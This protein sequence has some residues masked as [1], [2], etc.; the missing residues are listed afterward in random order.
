MYVQ[1]IMIPLSFFFALCMYLQYHTYIIMVYCSTASCVP[2]R[3]RV[4]NVLFWRSIDGQEKS[5][6]FVL[7]TFLFYFR[8]AIQNRVDSSGIRNSLYFYFV[9]ANK[10]NPADSGFHWNIPIPVDSSGIGL[11]RTHSKFDRVT[12]TTT[13][14]QY[15]SGRSWPRQGSTPRPHPTQDDSPKGNA[16][17][18]FSSTSHC[19][20][21][22]PNSLAHYGQRTARIFWISFPKQSHHLEKWTSSSLCP[23]RI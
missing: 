11:I 16:Q 21:S 14:P 15:A 6:G 3:R 22:L 5:S 1:Y 20:H 19:L 2:K 7:C 13:L 17:M 4:P 10:K 23:S 18:P 9:E 12:H 8:T